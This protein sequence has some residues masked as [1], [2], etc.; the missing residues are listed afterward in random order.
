MNSLKKKVLS[1]SPEI[2]D[3]FFPNLPIPGS[4]SILYAAEYL[5]MYLSYYMRL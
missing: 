4:F 1:A 3:L 2:R 5:I